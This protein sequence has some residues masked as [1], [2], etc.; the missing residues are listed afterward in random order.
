MDPDR[1]IGVNQK[2][3]TPHRGFVVVNGDIMGGWVCVCEATRTEIDDGI[4]IEHFGT[5][6]IIRP[7]RE[8]QWR[9]R[10]I[11]VVRRTFRAV[12]V[13][14]GLQTRKEERNGGLTQRGTKPGLAHTIGRPPPMEVLLFRRCVP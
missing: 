6:L 7:G 5:S 12:S 4:L 9:W 14:R 2:V 10:W 3:L 13:Q 1:R 11:M 8:A